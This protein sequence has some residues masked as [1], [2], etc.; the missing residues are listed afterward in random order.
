MKLRNRVVALAIALG[1]S[2]AS[3]AHADETARPE[4]VVRE[5]AIPAK[6]SLADALAIFRAQGL[7]LLIADAAVRNAQGDVASADRSPNPLVSVAAGPVFNYQANVNPCAGCTKYSLNWT[8]GDNGAITDALFGKRERRTHVADAALDV[9]RLARAD[10]QRVLESMVKQAYVQVSAAKAELDFATDFLGTLRESLELAKARYPG[11]ITEADLA[12]TEVQKLEGDSAVTNGV[13]S[14]RLA[15]ASLAFLLGARTVAVDFQTDPL[16]YAV[17]ASLATPDEATLIAQALR[18]RPDLLARR[19]DQTRALASLD[20][21]K[22]SRAPDIALSLQFSGVGVGRDAASPSAVVL[23]G[24]TNLPIF[25]QQG[26][27]IAKAEA[28]VLRATLTQAKA[29]SIVA[30]DVSSAL[31]AFVSSRRLVERMKTGGLLDRAKTARDIL[32]TAYRAGSA[33]LVD[34]LDA[35]R[36]FIA[37]N[38]EYIADL[39]QYWTAIYQLEQALGTEVR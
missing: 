22:L 33:S 36:T 27:E 2:A 8:V 14:Y 37:T 18:T 35:R 17:P 12:R 3:L 29:E 32:D 16:D 13:L 1:A 21:A 19:H 30:A 15:Q 4:V 11:V 9:A 6:L 38:E 20:L 5:V 31:G 23:N 7:D 26:G 28:D 24:S 10:A 25:Y 39:A 34:V